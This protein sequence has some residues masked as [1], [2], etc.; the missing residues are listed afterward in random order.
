MENHPKSV[1]NALSAVICDMEKA[2]MLY[3]KNP[4][5]DFT[6]N[7]KLPFATMIMQII[8]MGGNTLTK[9]LMDAFGYD[10]DSATSS[11]FVQQRDK[12][13]P[14]A[15]EFL[16]QE[17]TTTCAGIKRYKG[18]RLLAGDGSSLNIAH[19]PADPETY[20]C[21]KH[22][23]QGYNLLH[24]NA[25]YDL[26][27]KVYVD[28]IVQPGKGSEDKGLTA[29]V[30][31]SDINDRVIVTLDR[32]YESYNNMAHIEQKGWHYVIRVKDVLS[33]GGILSGLKLPTEGEFDIPFSFTLTRKQTNAVKSQSDCYKLLKKA[34]TFDYCD[35]HDNKFYPISFRVVRVLLPNGE[36][37]SLITNLPAIEFSSHDL[38]EIYK[39]RWGI[40]T[41]FR[42]L[43][44][45][46]GMANFHSK[47]REF[48]AQ[49][50]FARLVMYNFVSII[51]VAVIL[52]AIGKKHDY[53]VNFS[54]A[55]IVCRRFLRIRNNEPPLD[56]EALLKKCLTPIRPTRNGQAGT[57]QNTSK[58][59]FS[60][61]Y[62]IA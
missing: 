33:S 38:R 43:K 54:H 5:K 23:S 21:I 37:E 16:L 44:H 61:I 9:E 12:I 57:R 55:V 1:K 45:L 39:R 14:Q 51:T 22:T 6:R 34:T 60:F 7:R 4:E 26:C 50:I 15:F 41:S 49:E 35:L 62:R 47:K 36:Y 3:A 20:Y 19:N 29:M 10:P 30:D 13:L 31:R 24:L 2:S 11:A 32:G 40:E 52:P 59:P 58:A 46:I 25:L 28:A 48:I 18:C 42:E 27:S 8:C 56:I 17:F 53:R